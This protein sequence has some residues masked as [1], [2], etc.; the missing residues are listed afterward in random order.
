MTQEWLWFQIHH[1]THHL[2]AWLNSGLSNSGPPPQQQMLDEGLLWGGVQRSEPLF[3]WMQCSTVAHSITV[4]ESS[5]RLA[6]RTTHTQ[7]RTRGFTNLP[8]EMTTQLSQKLLKL[9]VAA[10]NGGF[11]WETLEPKRQFFTTIRAKL[12]RSVH[13]LLN[14]N[15]PSVTREFLTAGA[16]KILQL[17]PYPLG[18]GVGHNKH[19]SAPWVTISTRS[20]K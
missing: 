14:T 10:L 6:I 3:V 13:L 1:Q 7:G 19:W 17:F 4:K 9:T 8:V 5:H 20:L 18:L 15:T 2:T 11:H 12:G 16:V